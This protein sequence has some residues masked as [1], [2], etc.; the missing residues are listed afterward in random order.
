M[1]VVLCIL[2]G[3]T[4]PEFDPSDYPALSVLRRLWDVDTT[5]GESRKA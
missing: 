1:G 5:L 4:D 3:F 2:D